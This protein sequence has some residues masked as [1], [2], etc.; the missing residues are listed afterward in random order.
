MGKYGI[1]VLPSS[2]QCTEDGFDT[3]QKRRKR[4]SIQPDPGRSK[5]RQPAQNPGTEGANRNIPRKTHSDAVLRRSLRSLRTEG[6]AIG[7]ERR[8]RRGGGKG[9]TRERKEK[10]RGGARH[11]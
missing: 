1:A 3:A 7:E 9:A 2:S 6:V 5:T 8:R 4:E 10:R 11:R